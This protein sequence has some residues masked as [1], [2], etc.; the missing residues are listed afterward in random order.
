[1]IDSNIAVKI[2]GINKEIILLKI[3]DFNIKMLDKRNTIILRYVQNGVGINNFII[4][5]DSPITNT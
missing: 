5:P 1:M 3:V 2:N 4:I